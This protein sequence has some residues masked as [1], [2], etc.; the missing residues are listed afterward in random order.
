MAEIYG[1]DVSHW[2]NN[3]DW[4][5]VADSGK[6]FAILKCS[7]RLGKDS[8]FDSNYAK[9][10]ELMD[11]GCYIY[12]KVSNT[13]EAKS[14]AEYAVKC[15]GNKKMPCGVWLDLEDAAM[16]HLGKSTLNKIIETEA[17]IL[18]KAGYNV[19]IY[20]NKD[21]YD[22]VLDSKTLKATYPFW[23]ARYPSGDNGTVRESLSPK[24]FGV[25]WQYSSKGKVPG[26]SGNVDMNVAYK[27]F[28]DIFGAKA[29]GSAT[30]EP[31]T[32]SNSK[33]TSSTSNVV[34]F[35]KYTGSSNSIVDALKA[36]GVKDPETT[37]GKR[38]AIAKKNGIPTSSSVYMNTQL[39][40]LL[41]Q[42]KLIKV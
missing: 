40:K 38:K 29:A 28:N 9:A 20:C 6:K 10:S 31:T 11:V 5:K 15:L 3:I 33:E 21:W 24:S 19:G 23:I 12:N 7:Q 14:E 34:Y 4:K 18:K 25:I 39:L 8:K 13:A 30:K 27:S 35:K 37:L 26:I 16:R 2:Q 42:G 41:K 17:A 32:A 22:N 36:I 1:I